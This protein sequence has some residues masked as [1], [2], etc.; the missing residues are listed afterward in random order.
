MKTTKQEV[1]E[2]YQYFVEA[3][4]SEGVEPQEL[5]QKLAESYY[6]RFEEVTV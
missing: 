1:A 4:E 3:C 5:L 2:I 6:S